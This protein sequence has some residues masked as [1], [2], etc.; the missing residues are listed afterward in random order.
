MVVRGPPCRCTAAPALP[1]GIV[2]H[3][4]PHCPEPTDPLPESRSFSRALAPRAARLAPP[5]SHPATPLGPRRRPPPHPRR[6]HLS[7]L[8]GPDQPPE[9]AHP[10]PRAEPVVL[11]HRGGR[12]RAHGVPERG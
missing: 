7:S 4:A 11:E 3:E 10:R 9:R 6:R 1:C 2:K 8:L 12:R 5:R